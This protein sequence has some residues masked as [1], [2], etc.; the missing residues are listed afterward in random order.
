MNPLKLADLAALAIGQSLAVLT[1][2]AWAWGVWDWLAAA[3]PF[4]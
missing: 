1:T 3:H 2:A 4:K